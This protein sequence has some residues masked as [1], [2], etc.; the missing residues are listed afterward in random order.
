MK[1]NPLTLDS[2]KKTALLEN[3]KNYFSVEM[4]QDIGDLKAGFLLDFI[5]QNF[6]KEYYNRGV[7]DAKKFIFQKM[8]DLEID[9]DQVYI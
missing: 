8:E 2:D 5:E 6:G 1:P 9:M 3:I 4:D 7:T